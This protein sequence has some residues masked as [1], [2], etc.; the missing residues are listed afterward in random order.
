MF[1]FICLEDIYILINRTLFQ[2]FRSYNFFL[3]ILFLLLCVIHFF[4][5]FCFHFLFSI[6]Y[7]FIYLFPKKKNIIIIDRLCI[8][9]IFFLFSPYLYAHRKVF[10]IHY[11][12]MRRKFLT[13]KYE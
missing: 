5:L 9:I 4:F 1:L 12:T 11:F 3:K 7:L 8:V 6:Y 2:T 10:R 13:P